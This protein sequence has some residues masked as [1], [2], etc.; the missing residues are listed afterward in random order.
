MSKLMKALS[1][2]EISEFTEEGGYSKAECTLYLALCSSGYDCGTCSYI[3]KQCGYTPGGG[4]GGGCSG[5]GCTC[6]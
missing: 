4:S 1:N 5:S 6:H 3:L 2:E